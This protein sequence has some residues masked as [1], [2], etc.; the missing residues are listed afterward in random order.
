MVPIPTSVLALAL[1]TPLIEPRTSELEE[2][3]AE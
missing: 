3:T 1:L 2:P